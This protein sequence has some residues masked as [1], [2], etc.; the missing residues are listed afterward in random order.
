MHYLTTRRLLIMM[1][2]MFISLS[3]GQAVVAEEKPTGNQHQVPEIPVVIDGVK[4]PAEAVRE[5]NGRPLYFVVDE[6]AQREGVLYTFT[7]K[8]KFEAHITTHSLA[9][10]N[11]SDGTIGLFHQ[12]YNDYDTYFIE[13]PWYANCVLPLPVGSSIVTLKGLNRCG[14][15]DWNDDISSVQATPNGGGSYLY[16]DAYYSGSVLYVAP[17]RDIPE[18]RPYGFHNNVSSLRNEP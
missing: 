6:Q 14:N 18:L 15:G 4:R 17:G 11:L 9:Q 8:E 3:T 13:G 1:L 5:Y 10:A 7:S 2:V 12:N 16:T